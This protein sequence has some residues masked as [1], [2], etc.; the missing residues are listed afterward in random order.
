MKPHLALAFV[1]AATPV[2]AQDASRDDA[3]RTYVESIAMQSALDQQLLSTDAY[4]SQVQAGGVQL[5]AEGARTLT[6]IVDEEFTD[7]RPGLQEALT[8]AAAETFTIEEL[9]ALN[10]FYGSEAGKSV[11]AKMAPF[12]QDFYASIA[13]TL[14]DTQE[15]IATRARD[16]LAPKAPPPVP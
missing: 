1:L 15:Q 7:V 8:A 2:L 13:P 4:I 5:D 16:A 9:D 6:D 10:T 14:R 11:A 12:M 3:A